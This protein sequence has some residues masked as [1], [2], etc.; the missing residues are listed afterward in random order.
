MKLLREDVKRSE[1]E[2]PLVLFGQGIRAEATRYT[3]TS[4]LRKVVCEFL[5]EVLEGTFEERVAQ[6]VRYGRDDPAW[7]RDLLASLAR[8]LR[9]RTKLDRNDTDYLNPTSI[10]SFF[11]P[12]KK[13]FDMNDVAISWNRIYSTYPELDN[14]SGSSGWTRKDIAAML[15]RTRNTQDRALILL[16]ASSGVRSGALS[17]LNWGDLRPVYRAGGRLTLDPGEEGGELACAALEVYRGSSE[18]YTAFATPEAFA[19][20]QEYG[21]EWFNMAG[22]QA[23]PNDPIFVTTRVIP[24]R[25]AKQTIQKRIKEAVEKSGLRDAGK[26]GKRFRVPL[27]NGFRRFYNKTCKEAAMSGDSTLGSL[28]KKEYMMGHRGLTSLDE[29]YFKTDVLELAAEYVKAVPDLTIDDA[30]RLRRSNRALAENIQNMEDEKDVEIGRLKGQVR[31]MEER[32]AELGVGGAR[33]DEMLKAILESPKA[34]GVP[35]DVMEALRG[36]LDALAAAQEGEMRKM[37]AEYDAKMDKVLRAMD[38]MG[39]KGG[40]GNDPLREFR[41]NGV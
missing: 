17:P 12:V 4:V 6:L 31:D 30:D 24:K 33:A 10:S 13:L 40:Y 27:M 7:T 26:D 1:D 38:D 5:E 35:G 37:K 2:D 14:M 34:G 22:R 29:N 9:E 16:L 18:S 41:D 19:A 15:K 3:Y 36:M 20:I 8:K 11:K 25:A 39:R 32:I 23:G 21:R 28:I